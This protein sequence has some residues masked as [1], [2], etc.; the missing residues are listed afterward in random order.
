M[1]AGDFDVASLA[2]YLHVSPQQVLRLVQRDKLPGRR[3]AGQWR[4]SRAE[5]HRWLEKS[6]GLADDKELQEME[7]LL[8]RSA[9]SQTGDPSQEPQSLSELMPK[10]LIAIPLPAKTKESVIRDIVDLAVDTGWL[11]DGAKMVAAVKAREDLHPTALDNGVAL[12]HPR[13]PL[14]SILGRAFVAFAR[15][16]RGIPFG[17]SAGVLTDLFFLLCSLS[18]RAHLQ[19]LARLSR[20]LVAP[21]FLDAL[22]STGS[23]ESVHDLVALTEKDLPN[24]GGSG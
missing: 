24:L 23:A 13:R 8:N 18:D 19:T 9:A 17:N 16:S 11:W 12:L 6:I 15:T 4:F 2:A 7:G 10:N 21:G 20:L 1:P 22:R 3:V 14:P 5:I